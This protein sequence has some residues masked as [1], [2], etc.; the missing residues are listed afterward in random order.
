M[1]NK[2]VKHYEDI[3]KKYLKQETWIKAYSLYL[4]NVDDP[5]NNNT[6][7][8]PKS[9]YIDI[10]SVNTNGVKVH[11]YYEDLTYFLNIQN[12]E[13]L[14]RDNTFFKKPDKE[15]KRP[16]NLTIH[17]SN[18]KKNNLG[19]IYLTSDT[20]AFSEPQLLSSGEWKTTHPLGAYLE[21]CKTAKKKIQYDFI[22][23]Y[24]YDTRTIGGAFIWPKIYTGG[25]WVS[26]Y[27]S[28][29]GVKVRNLGSYI[30][31]RVDLTLQ[32]IKMFYHFSQEN[33]E[34]DKKIIEKMNK[35]GYML[36]KGKDADCLC[37]W[38]RYFGS[39]EDY[40]KFFC[41]EDFI[42]GDCNPI[43]IITEKAIES[44]GLENP[45]I[46]AKFYMNEYKDMLGNKKDIEKMLNFVSERILSR[47]RII[48]KRLLIKQKVS[49]TS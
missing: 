41:F 44:I 32:E 12:K 20:F 1:E 8:K 40:V 5:G 38:L 6:K 45:K 23:Q 39:F 26:C 34:D 31:D 42:V 24:L 46:D 15:S 9:C 29:R 27:N 49:S 30:N 48:E 2:E 7:P 22:A 13:I 25:K 36:L 14:K 18:D 28:K 35:N 3:R 21:L 11:E 10:D 47:S 16:G 4:K 43:N 17:T 19:E 37:R 33:P